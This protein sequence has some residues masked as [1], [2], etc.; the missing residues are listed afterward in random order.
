MRTW[1]TLQI[2]RYMTT[3]ITL[4]WF[5]INNGNQIKGLYDIKLVAVGQEFTTENGVWL[6]D[7]TPGWVAAQPSPAQPSPAQ[8][9]PAR[10]DHTRD[11]WDPVQYCSSPH[12]WETHLQ[13]SSPP[14]LHLSPSKYRA[15]KMKTNIPSSLLQYSVVCKS[16]YK[17]SP[18]T[19]SRI[20]YYTLQIIIQNSKF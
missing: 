6:C 10:T 12:S 20:S 2:Q 9:R 3:K 17:S 14:S 5:I 18:N 7:V 4:T 15:F 11:T 16:L 1:H 19:A 8:P 13:Y